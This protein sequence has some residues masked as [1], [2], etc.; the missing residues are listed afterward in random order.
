MIFELDIKKTIKSRDVLFYETIFP[1]STQE[2]LPTQSRTQTPL[3]LDPKEDEGVR[4]TKENN[5]N[6]DIYSSSM[7]DAILEEVVTQLLVQST[8]PIQEKKKGLNNWKI[9][10]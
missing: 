5:S 3:A 6:E 2:P 4:K 10:S 7:N 9:K 1:F 8:R